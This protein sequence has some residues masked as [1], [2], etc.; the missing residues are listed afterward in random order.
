MKK[1][2]GSCPSFCL[3][4]SSLVI[5]HF[6]SGFAAAQ[7]PAVSDT[8]ILAP[9]AAGSG[10]IVMTGRVLDYTGAALTYETSR[11]DKQTLPGK[12]VLEIKSTWVAAHT[13][14]DEAW[15]QRD[16]EAAAKQYQA[17][18]TAEPRRWA[19]RLIVSRLVAAL[20]ENERWESAAEQFLAL[21]RDD[22]TTPYFA[23]A[24]LVWTTANVT[25][26]LETKARAWSDDR[27]SSVAALVGSSYLLSTALRS[28]GV[29][30]LG[31][32]KLD[33]DPRVARLAEAQLWRVAAV[34]ADAA[35]IGSW[36]TALEKFPADLQAGPWLVVGRAWATRNE[37]E[38]AAL[39]LMRVPILDG[40]EQPRS[41]AEALWS[42]GQ[43]LERLARPEQAATLYRELVRDYPATPAAATAR[44]RLAE[45][46]P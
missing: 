26:T 40:D 22:P 44:D 3:F 37:P 1:E 29:R 45:L 6:L 13:A 17:A 16:F 46:N 12:N 27:T 30:R 2:N 24:P 4:H 43:S 14:G 33:A 9:R 20:R 31:E 11:G 21:V 39:A 15:K 23:V 5:F 7:L 8:I 34:T 42:A 38:R 19:K 28:D 18:V 25:P 35:T 36:E 41:A 10:R 32:L